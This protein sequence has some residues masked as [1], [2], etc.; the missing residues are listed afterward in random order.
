MFKLGK[1]NQ[2]NYLSVILNV[3]PVITQHTSPKK[4]MSSMKKQ[5]EV[6]MR[7]IGERKEPSKE[8]LDRFITIYLRMVKENQAKGLKK[9]D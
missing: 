2:V 1:R 4:E 8:A 7:C 5:P 9:R 6:I 3:V